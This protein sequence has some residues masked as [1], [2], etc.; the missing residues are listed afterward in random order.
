M[1]DYILDKVS[2]L[3][4]SRT[5]RGRKQCFF[6][7]EKAAIDAHHKIPQS[8]T[9]RIPRLVRAEVLDEIFGKNPQRRYPLCK[10]CHKKLHSVLRPFEKSILLFLDIRSPEK[11]IVEQMMKDKIL[12]IIGKDGRGEDYADLE[13][14]VA[15][16]ERRG[17]SREESVRLM[18]DL[19]DDGSIY[20]VLP[21][22]GSARHD[23]SF[24]NKISYDYDSVMKARR[25][26]RG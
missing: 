24:V 4:E 6:C 19:R 17:V 12:M 3:L 9:K 11:R 14:I 23:P 16:L 20:F 15:K 21:D 13:R 5:S 7:G 1:H 25:K 26:V 18:K 2:M 8:I 10:N 22:E